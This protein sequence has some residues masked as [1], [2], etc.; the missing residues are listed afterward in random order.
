VVGYKWDDEENGARP[1]RIIEENFI[2]S[3]EESYKS[4][5]GREGI[6]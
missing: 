4:H 3:I 1:F 2:R 6:A 5:D